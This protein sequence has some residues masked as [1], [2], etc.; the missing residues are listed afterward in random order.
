MPTL[1]F[2]GKN[3]IYAHHLTVPYRPLQVDASR[4]VLPDSESGDSLSIDQNLIIHGDNLHALKALLPH[5]AGRVKCIYIDPP[6]NTGNEDWHYNDNVNSPMMQDWLRKH[7]PV[8]GEDLERHDKWLCMMWPRMHLL[9]ELLSDDGTIF[10]SID[11]NEHH[12][13]TMLMDEIFG[14]EN[15]CGTFVWERKKK[16]SFLDRNMGTITEYVVAYAQYR[17][18]SP[19]FVE[20]SVELGKRYPFNNASNPVGILHFPAGCVRFSIRDQVIKSQDMSTPNIVTE[21]LD[22][23]QILNHTNANKFRLKGAW[24][25]SQSKLDEF[26]TNGDEITISKIPFRPN[27]VNRAGKVKKTV[28]L[29]S[30]RTNNVPTN[31][32]ATEELRAIFDDIESDVFDYPKPT[33]LLSYLIRAVSSGNDIVL[34]SFAGSGTAGHAVLSA[35]REDGSDRRFIM[36]ECED[37]YADGLTA[38]RVRRVIRGV[39]NAKDKQLREGLGGSFA[40]CTLGEA[41]DVDSL[42]EGDALPAFIDLASYLLHTATGISASPGDLNPSDDDGH[43]YSSDTQDYY[44]T[45]EPSLDFLRDREAALN[46]ERAERIREKGR[47]AVVFAAATYI[48]QSVLS[49]WHI[50]FCQLPYELGIGV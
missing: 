28:N 21:L 26:V 37:K 11:D 9:R 23:V 36:V 45:Y 22:D 14:E 48:S 8:D 20:G 38:E 10:V 32:D 12:H 2:K 19:A 30:Y 46:L 41:I 16:P 39:P 34:D 40:Y 27:Y 5:Y 25:Y 49:K 35:N 13:L 17:P 29:L 6:Y 3:H 18:L 43:F 4:S 1:D 15:Y 33:G 31:E 44:L 47:P 50:T 7:G 24:R 42:L